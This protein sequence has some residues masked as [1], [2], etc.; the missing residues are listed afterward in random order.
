MT[1]PDTASP[2]RHPRLARI[3]EGIA[4][5]AG[6]LVRPTILLGCYLI[7]GIVT[8]QVINDAAKGLFL[9]GDQLSGPAQATRDLLR[10]LGVLIQAA[11]AGG[12]SANAVVWLLACVAVCRALIVAGRFAMRSSSLSDHA[13]RA[14]ERTA[15]ATGGVAVFL[16]AS[17]T[18]LRTH[19]HPAPPVNAAWIATAVFA[20]IVAAGA[21]YL[22]VRIA[23]PAMP[24]HAPMGTARLAT[25]A[26]PQ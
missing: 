6:A 10:N 17:A 3:A 18:Y 1:T 26:R 23:L 14:V 24:M 12:N 8:A 22:A 4:S 7:I 11:A 9:R 2:R 16:V 5:G 21:R 13:L 25:A 20:L 15:G 19:G